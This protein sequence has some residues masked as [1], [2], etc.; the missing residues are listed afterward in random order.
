MTLTAYIAEYSS[1]GGE[2]W[3]VGAIHWTLDSAVSEANRRARVALW[4]PRKLELHDRGLVDSDET[5]DA[6]QRVQDARKTLSRG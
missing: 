1:D 3:T 2:T 4:R 5:I 6:Y